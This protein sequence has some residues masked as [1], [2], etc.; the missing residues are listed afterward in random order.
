MTS[1][2]TEHGQCVRFATSRRGL[3]R[4][5]CFHHWVSP[6]GVMYTNFAR[7]HKSC[8]LISRIHRTPH[9]TGAD[10]LHLWR[11][12]VRFTAVS[13]VG[14]K[15]ALRFRDRLYWIGPM[16]AIRPKILPWFFHRDLLVCIRRLYVT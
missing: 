10:S 7:N 2:L 4:P 13:L 16:E 3:R 1:L 8:F 15:S 6:P 12:D 5:L 11:F 9:H 14:I